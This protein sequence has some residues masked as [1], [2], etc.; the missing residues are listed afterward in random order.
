MTKSKPSTPVRI[1]RSRKSR[2]TSPPPNAPTE[3]YAVR[4]V[5]RSGHQ[6]ENYKTWPIG[7]YLRYRPEQWEDVHGPGG[8][9][10]YDAAKLDR[11]TF[12]SR[13]GANGII[14]FM[15]RKFPGVEC[16]RVAFVEAPRTE[17]FTDKYGTHERCP[18]GGEHVPD[19]TTKAPADGMPELIDVWCSKCGRSGSAPH[20]RLDELQW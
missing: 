8:W 15:Q 14:R 16:E 3:I 4:I 2:E 18:K 17:S 11:A 1:P 9:A 10:G 6:A 19:W 7:A 20:N 5:S 12:T 13:N